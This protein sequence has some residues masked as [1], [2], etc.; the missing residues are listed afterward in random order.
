VISLVLRGRPPAGNL[1]PAGA[2]RLPKADNAHMVSSSEDP[3]IANTVA[4][5]RV[6]ID[7]L[8]RDLSREL[9]RLTEPL[10]LTFASLLSEAVMRERRLVRLLT[11][12]QKR[13]YGESRIT[14]PDEELRAEARAELEALMANAMLSQLGYES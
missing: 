13:Q 6:T 1:A 11:E 9:P 2:L 4:A 5:L 3:V 14:E 10:V 8:S 12:D 7:T